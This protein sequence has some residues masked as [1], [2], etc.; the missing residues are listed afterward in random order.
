MELL[1]L[2]ANFLQGITSWF[3][4]PFL[5]NVRERGVLF[6]RGLD[7]I[8]LNP[9]LH[10][11]TPLFSSYERFSIMKGANEFP[12]VVLPT[13]DDKSVAIGFVLVWHIEAKDVITAA[14]STEDLEAMAGEVGE[15]LLPPLVMSNTWDTLFARVRGGDAASTSIGK[16]R[17]KTANASLTEDAQALLEPY[18]ITVDSARVNFLAKS[19]VFNILGGSTLDP[20]IK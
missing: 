4:R 9:G 7:P 15:S 6:R 14:T 11:H 10:W 5:I 2:F 19:R 17:L 16:S 20:R 8:L 3:P 13:S 12:A 1:Q 18:G